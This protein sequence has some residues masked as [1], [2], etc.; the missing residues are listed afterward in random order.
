MTA[1][2]TPLGHFGNYEDAFGS[3]NTSITFS[4]LVDIKLAVSKGFVMYNA[5]IVDCV[6][7]LDVLTRINQGRL[8]ESVSVS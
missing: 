2:L 8:K 7:S 4:R 3:C 5:N 6:R 1:L